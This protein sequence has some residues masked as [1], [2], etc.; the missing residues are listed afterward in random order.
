MHL[1]GFRG[2]VGLLGVAC[3]LAFTSVV[4]DAQTV[5]N[6]TVVEFSP[7][8]SHNA[9]NPDGTPVVTDYTLAVFVPGQTTPVVTTSL[10][11][12]NPDPDGMIRASLS[13]SVTSALTPTVVYEARVSAVGPGGTG[14]SSPSNSFT[15]QAACAPAISPTGQAA[16]AAGGSGTVTVTAGAGCAW[17]AVANAAWLSIG[18]G[19]SGNGNGSVSYSV[20]ANT[21]TASRSATLTIGG[22]T[23]TVTQAGLT[24]SYTISPASQSVPAAGG[25][26]SVSLTAPGGCTWTASSSAAWLS[27]TAGTSGSSNGSVSYS[28]AANTTTASRSATLTIGGQTFT[29]TQAGAASTEGSPAGSE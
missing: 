15:F 28:V 14:Q 13:T 8:A 22:Q 18:S 2:T 26:G 17:S 3:V 16:P 19:A 12:L 24:C 11:K 1:F 6:P 25:T 9:V 7:S 4:A 21:T 5:V 27:I 23:F 20:A 10:G 29:V